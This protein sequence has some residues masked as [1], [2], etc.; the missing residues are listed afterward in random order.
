MMTLFSYAP[1]KTIAAIRVMQMSWE[2]K[3]W[4]MILCQDL[5]FPYF[6]IIFSFISKYN[7]ISFVISRVL[8]LILIQYIHVLYSSILKGK[9]QQLILEILI[10]PYVNHEL[11]VHFKDTLFSSLVLIV[12]IHSNI[13]DW[14]VSSLPWH[15][16][17]KVLLVA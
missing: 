9:L 15:F 13:S 11:W 4:F 17:A 10:N 3:L 6:Y 7:L 12:V 1:Q 14:W 8:L 16:L 5:W 2:I